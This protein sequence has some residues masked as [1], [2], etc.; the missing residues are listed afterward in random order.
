MRE[1]GARHFRQILRFV[2][3]A[4]DIEGEEPFPVPVLEELRE[5]IPSDAVSFSELDRVG[6]VGLGLVSVGEED[7][8]AP[9]EEVYWQLRHEYPTCAYQ[10]RTLD[11]SALTLSDFVSRRELRRRR[12]YDEWFRPLG[13]EHELTAG[14]DS[15][16]SHTKVFLFDRR[17]GKDFSERDRAVLDALRPWLARLYRAAERR[18]GVSDASSHD[19]RLTARE[20]EI[21]ELVA[22]GMTNA[23][24]AQALWLSPGTVRRHL[25]NAYRKLGVHTRTAAVAQLRQ[26]SG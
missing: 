12:L 5:L 8:E 25:E 21:L 24:V 2:G 3:L 26:L 22:E 13:I 18:R 23:E 10:E 9:P 1:L 19:P 6:R 20:H 14:L 15:P 4:Q 17:D 16:L 7:I 11:W